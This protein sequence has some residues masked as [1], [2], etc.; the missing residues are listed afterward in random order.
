MQLLL[1][2]LFNE[3][4]Q[5]HL[6]RGWLC[7]DKSKPWR[8]E[9][10]QDDVLLPLSILQ[11]TYLGCTHQT[12]GDSLGKGKS[13]DL[14][15]FTY[16]LGDDYVNAKRWNWFLNKRVRFSST[17]ARTWE[18]LENWSEMDQNGQSRI[19]Y[20]CISTRFPLLVVSP[21][22]HVSVRVTSNAQLLVQSRVICVSSLGYEM[23][24][25]R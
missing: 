14:H 13:A 8:T 11:S 5:S 24:T 10:L 4:L 25:E 2:L 7:C 1:L 17:K 20:F 3:S 6:S 23:A 19:R 12:T 18:V 16:W 22:Y 15:T 9:S 21:K